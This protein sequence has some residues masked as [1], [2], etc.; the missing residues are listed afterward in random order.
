MTAAFLFESGPVDLGINDHAQTRKRTAEFPGSLQAIEP[1]H[2]EIQE[3]EI[4]PMMRCQL[5]GVLAVT[6]G[7][8]HF[9]APGE[10][11]IVTNGSQSGRG[12]VRDQN[13]N[14]GT[15]GHTYSLVI[16]F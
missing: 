11:K 14:R 4:G 7:A 6:G 16:T 10:R 15:G 12:I 8:N 5:N 3:R 2:A 1:G 13:T 9:E